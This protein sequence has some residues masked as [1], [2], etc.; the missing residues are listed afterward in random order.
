MG[1][2]DNSSI[3]MG[4]SHLF[5]PVDVL[6]ETWIAEHVNGRSRDYEN[7]VRFDGPLLEECVVMDE[8]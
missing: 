8:N 1:D 3:A 6:Q 7:P 4:I 2:I 5:Q